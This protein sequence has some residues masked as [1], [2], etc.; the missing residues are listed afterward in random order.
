M[1]LANEFAINKYT[2]SVNTYSISLII[3][4]VKAIFY[5][6][7]Y[8]YATAAQSSARQLYFLTNN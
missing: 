2:K 8:I 5:W 1:Y 3:S 6:L 4:D 7:V